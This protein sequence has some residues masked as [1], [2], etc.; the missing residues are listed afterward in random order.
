MKLIYDPHTHTYY[1]HGK[2]S[3]MEMVQAAN[4]AGLSG[5]HITEHGPNHFYARRMDTSAYRRMRAEVDEAK[6]AYPDMDIKFGI[7][8]NIISTEGDID[9]NDEILPL[10]DVV[11][12]GFH[13]M[14]KMK[15]MRSFFLLLLT[16]I[17]IKKLRFKFLS[18]G[19]MRRNTAAVIKML[20][21]YKINMITHPC[22]NYSFD[23]V[24]VAEKCVQKGTLLEINNPRR[25]ANAK[26]IEL[27]EPTGVLFALGS[28]AHKAQDVG[29]VANALAIVTEAGL[30]A[31]RI[32]NVTT[33]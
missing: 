12:A 24:A 31:E 30:P 22:S 14:C 33:D 19:A 17:A 11:N 9:V 32:V 3:V 7:E 28:D 23:I 18:Q 25:L 1:S 16:T 29:N 4:E 26:M 5:I 8:A 15:N 27:V 10:F 2:N 13:M 6:K 20:D 21:K